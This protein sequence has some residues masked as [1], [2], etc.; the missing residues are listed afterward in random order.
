[1]IQSTY[2]RCINVACSIIATTLLSGCAAD[3]ARPGTVCGH[4]DYRFSYQTPNPCDPCVQGVEL[5]CYGHTPTSW[6]VWPECCNNPLQE[7][8]LRERL[9]EDV[10]IPGTAP[11]PIPANENPDEPTP[12]SGRR[13]FNGR[14]GAILSPEV[15][16]G[17]SM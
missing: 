1:M 7:P 10:P 8:V 14:L 2:L 13:N 16:S 9:P 15:T 6:Q 12:K 4:C 5:P 17:Q 11:P 3:S